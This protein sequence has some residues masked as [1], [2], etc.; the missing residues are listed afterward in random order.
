MKCERSSCQ[1][2][3]RR[4]NDNDYENDDDNDDDEN[5]SFRQQ[6]ATA[7][8]KRKR[9]GFL[10]CFFALCAE[11]IRCAARNRVCSDNFC[12]RQFLLVQNIK[13]PIS[14]FCSLRLQTQAAVIWCGTKITIIFSKA[15][16][17]SFFLYPKM[18]LKSSFLVVLIGDS[19]VGKSNLLSRFTRNE[20]N[21]DSKSTIGVGFATRTLQA[22]AKM[23]R[24]S[25]NRFIS[26]I[27]FVC[28]LKTNGF[29]RK[30]KF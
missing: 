8:V 19:G 14:K 24:N 2:G 17:E 15:R 3:H 22:S 18:C 7:I 11:T 6:A 25:K 5:C 26:T 30:C 10:F 29:E 12:S 21:I 20:F 16:F 27:Q 9:G 23:R 4:C 1:L 28:R 13:S